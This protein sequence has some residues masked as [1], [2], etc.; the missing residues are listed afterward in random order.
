MALSD[1]TSSAA[2]PTAPADRDDLHDLAG[3]W[4]GDFH[5]AKLLDNILLRDGIVTLAVGPG[6]AW[7]A[8]ENF[9]YVVKTANG[10]VIMTTEASR[11]SGRVDSGA[12]KFAPA[13]MTRTLVASGVQNSFEVNAMEIRRKPDGSIELT[14]VGD[15][16][17][18]VTM[19]RRK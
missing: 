18:R 19:E 6:D 8:T 3:S 4:G 11:S 17:Y 14:Y 1:A 10:D 13:M 16:G 7:R 5:D 9:T 2:T 15:G 12:L